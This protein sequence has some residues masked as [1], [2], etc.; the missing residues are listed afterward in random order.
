[1]IWLKYYYLNRILDWFFNLE[2]EKKNRLLKG[3]H[4][5]L[6][7][8]LRAIKKEVEKASNDNYEKVTNG[9]IL[10]FKKNRVR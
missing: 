9:A 6:I 4:N 2:Y 5:K 3:D 1:M 7:K 10:H 8:D